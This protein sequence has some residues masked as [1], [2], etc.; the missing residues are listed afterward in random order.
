MDRFQ[1]LFDLLP[2]TPEILPT[3]RKLVHDYRVSGIQVHDARIVAA[4][5]VHQVDQILSFDLDDFKRYIGIQSFIRWTWRIERARCAES[6][7]TSKDPTLSKHFE[8]MPSPSRSTNRYGWSPREHLMEPPSQAG[9]SSEPK[10]DSG[11][12]PQSPSF[13]GFFFTM[14][15]ASKRDRP[16]QGVA[17]TTLTITCCCSLKSN[18]SSGRKHSILVSRFGLERHATSCSSLAAEQT[19]GYRIAYGS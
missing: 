3:W 18:A 7:S 11:I 10:A 15:P 19:A 5:M 1:T 2:E 13:T 8:N 14:Y 4:M 16:E 9:R 12:A 17:L 6:R